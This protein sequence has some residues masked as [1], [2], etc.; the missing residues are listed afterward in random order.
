MGPRTETQD[1]K[2]NII[3]WIVGIAFTGFLAVGAGQMVA[4]GS[5]KAQVD[6]DSKKIDIVAKDYVPMWFLEG[7]EQNRTYQTEEI[8]A[9]LKGDQVAIK[10]INAK[11]MEFQKTMMSNFIQMRGGYSTTTR[12]GNN[13]SPK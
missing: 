8:V 3:I 6:I 12:G 9:T 1:K 2:L 10:E 7:L 4:F 11:Y 13:S 5:V